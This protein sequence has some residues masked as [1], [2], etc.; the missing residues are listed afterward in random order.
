MAS[1]KMGL[2]SIHMQM[3]SPITTGSIARTRTK[4]RR[5]RRNVRLITGAKLYL[6][7]LRPRENPGIAVESRNCTQG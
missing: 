3:Q 1:G 7:K 2:W 5:L 4:R 6:A